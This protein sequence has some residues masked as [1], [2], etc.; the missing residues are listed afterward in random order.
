GACGL[1]PARGPLS[2]SR[3]WVL[4][5]SA[6]GG[7]ASWTTAA[8]E[9]KPRG[10]RRGTAWSL[11]WGHRRR[12]GD[13]ADPRAV[14]TTLAAMGGV[15]SGGGAARPAAHPTPPRHG[16]VPD[17]RVPPAAAARPANPARLPARAGTGLPG[18]A[19]AA[20]R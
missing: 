3:Q 2:K 9:G 6:G 20:D 11:G 10:K 13:G 15:L 8:G 7:V 18:L 1:G 14:T 16:R 17:R 19:A 4:S 5:A 12:G